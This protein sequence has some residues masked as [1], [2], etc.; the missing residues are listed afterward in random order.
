MPNND[1]GLPDTCVFLN[2]GVPYFWESPD[3]A[4]NGTTGHAQVGANTVAVTVRKKAECPVPGPVR[5]D[6]FVC[7]PAVAVVPPGAGVPNASVQ[8]PTFNAGD[9]ST[10]IGVGDT[11]PATGTTVSFTWSVTAPAPGTDPPDGPGHRCLVARAYPIAANT[12][13]PADFHVQTGPGQGD[14]HVVQKNIQIDATRGM[15]RRQSKFNAVT[16]DG[17]TRGRVTVRAI[18]N[19]HPDDRSLAVL[20]PML[21]GVTGFRQIATRAPAEFRVTAPGVPDAEARDHTR[22]GCL[23]FLFKGSA[24]P[25]YELDLKLGPHQ[26]TGCVLETDLSASAPGDA[27]VFNLTQINE[28]DEAQGGLTVVTV[29]V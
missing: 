19:L 4:L 25:T 7:N 26:L 24:A 28:K 1:P 18:A 29:H 22:P 15:M 13:D 10:F 8:I 6:L 17:R 21:R 16:L 11:I 2:P 20:L 27:H 9:P 3:I 5:I 14:Q 12:P 23:G